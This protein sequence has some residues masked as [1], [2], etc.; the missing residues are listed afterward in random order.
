LLHLHVQGF[1]DTVDWLFV[2]YV[3]C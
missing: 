3:N 1:V 2:E